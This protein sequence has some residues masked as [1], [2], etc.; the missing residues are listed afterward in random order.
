MRVPVVP[1]AVVGIEIVSLSEAVNEMLPLVAVPWDS[2]QVYC[3]STVTVSVR[4][5]DTVKLAA[6]PSVTDV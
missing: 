5:R 1:V 2:V 6:F 4:D 3:R